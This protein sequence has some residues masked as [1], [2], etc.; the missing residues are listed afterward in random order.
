MMLMVS[1]L[2]LFSISLLIAFL[3]VRA[4]LSLVIASVLFENE[5]GEEI[6]I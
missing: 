5:F 3:M 4:C 1:C 2:S 6:V